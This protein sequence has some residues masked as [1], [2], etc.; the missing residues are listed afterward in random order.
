MALARASGDVRVRHEMHEVELQTVKDGHCFL[1][2][3]AGASQARFLFAGG[4]LRTET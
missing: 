3:L 1:H 4:F 2:P